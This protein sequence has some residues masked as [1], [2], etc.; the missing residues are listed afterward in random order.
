MKTLFTDLI[1]LGGMST[2]CY[3]TY[4]Q[5]GTAITCMVAGSLLLLYA[6]LTARGDK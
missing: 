3:G 1:G 4:L 5:Y 2:L 6:V